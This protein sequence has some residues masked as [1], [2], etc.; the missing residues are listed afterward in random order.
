MTNPFLQPEDYQEPACPLCMNGD[1]ANR[2]PIKRIVEKLDEYL[3]RNDYN[4]AEKHL[5]YWIT[6]A[7]VSGD[8]RGKLTLINERMGLYRKLARKDEAVADAATGIDLI[9]KL[10]LQNDTTAG[11]TYLN[12][13][14]VYKA[15]GDSPKAILLYEKSLSIY[16]K[17]LS[18][19]DSLFGGLYNNMALALVD[20]QEFDR[21]N[22][23][24][25]KA[26]H[27]MEHI[28]NGELE[29]AITYLNMAD[30][31]AKELGNPQADA[32]ISD[33]VSKAES[34][35]EAPH[36]PR[37]GYYAFVCEKCAP[38]FRY[39]GYFSYANELETRA[40]RIYE[41]S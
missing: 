8:L 36:L 26:L 22:T 14:T 6:E 1:T 13:A 34:L 21:A 3:N 25:A 15:F 32:V 38:T 27:V 10:H 17:T 23:F 41:G 5:N 9:N 31:A 11:T 12:A 35:L 19:T 28:E 20:Q 30:A 29:Q 24:Y 33:Y 7:V 39:Y 37:N 18:P 16:H 4:N 2:I 40:R